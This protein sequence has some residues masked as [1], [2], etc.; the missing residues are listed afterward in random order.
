MSNSF[1]KES[2]RRPLALML[3]ALLAMFVA[4][5]L[6]A[7][8]NANNT[9]STPAKQ[10]ATSTEATTEETATEEATTEEAA[11]EEAATEETATGEV[12]IAATLDRKSVV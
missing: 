4:L 7:C 11:P 5:P 6:A 12:D 10:E 3:A 2:Q 8:N 9:G 1:G